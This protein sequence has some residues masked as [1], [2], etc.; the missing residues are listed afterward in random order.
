MTGRTRRF[1]ANAA[2]AVI[3]MVFGQAVLGTGAGV[4]GHRFASLFHPS[5]GKDAS[6]YMS[7]AAELMLENAELREMAARS[8]RYRSMLHYTRM[9][10]ISAIYARVL[11]RSEGLVRGNLFID[12]GR[13][14]GLYPGAVCITSRGLVGLVTQVENETATVTPITSPSIRVSCVTA[15]TGSPGI[16]SATSGGGLEMRHVDLSLSPRVGE[17]VL[18]GSFGGVYP[19]GIVI[20]TVT[21]VREGSRGLDLSLAVSPAVSFSMLDEVLVLLSSPEP[22]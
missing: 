4:L 5:R 17:T 7:L 21:D 10:E 13:E 11:F 15:S 14:H 3:L 12:R 6:E 22:R 20:G 2:A 1:L 9:P 18:T 8:T 19:D 16:L